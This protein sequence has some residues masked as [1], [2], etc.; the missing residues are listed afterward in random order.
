[1][2][3]LW[4]HHNSFFKELLTLLLKQRYVMVRIH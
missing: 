4:N 2:E 3:Q 1:M